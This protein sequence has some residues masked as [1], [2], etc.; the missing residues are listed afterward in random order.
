[1]NR[2]D[3]FKT[4]AL[5]TGALAQ[6]ARATP[7]PAANDRIGIGVIGC[8]GMGRM[9]LADF[10]KQPEAE[11]VAVCDV[12]Q[13]NLQ[14]AHQLTDGKARTYSDF[15]KLL[16]DRAVDAVV[17]AT[18]DHWHPLIAVAACQAGKDVYV[19]KP[20]SNVVR[21]GRL[22][23]DA[24]RRNRRIVQV[25]LQQRSGSH[26]QRA[27]Q[28]VRSGDLGEI[29]YVQTW[30]H[31]TSSP[32]GLGIPPDTDPPAGLDYDFWL[33]PAPKV[34]FNPARFLGNWRSF[35]AYGG[36]RITDWGVHLVDIVH[37]AMGVDTPRAVTASGGKLYVQ[38]R[39][40]TPDTQEVTWEYP[41]FLLHYTCLLHNSYGHNGDAGHKPFGSYGIQFHGTRGTLF[42][43]RAG[44]Q[45]TPQMKGHTEPGGISFRAAF[46]DLTG[47]SMYYELEGVAGRGTTS[48]QHVPH[49]RNFL[50]C[51]TSREMPVADIEIGHRTTTA[52]H[53]GNIALRLERKLHWDGQAERFIGNDTA[54]EEANRMLVRPYRAPWK[55][56]GM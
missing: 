41:G 6:Q 46:D 54:T 29:H 20:V 52:C 14:E 8:G 45:V 36:G 30:I 16:D 18:P 7:A 49:V 22:M 5:S 34:P 44:Y 3:L 10:Q 43:D 39:R 35:F 55:L 19:E 13:P 11:I 23:V 42:V 33:G 40:D 31:E 21:E 4:A 1:M 25:G 2:R 12:Y 9:D 37:M 26:F 27:A 28:I 32:E 50:K 56:E 47:V 53:L 17:V 48:V 15:R 38:D 24:A 51:V